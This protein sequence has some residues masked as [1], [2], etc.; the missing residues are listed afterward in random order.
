MVGKRMNVVERDTSF[1]EMVS[2]YKK[3]MGTKPKSLVAKNNKNDIL[4]VLDSDLASTVFWRDYEEGVRYVIEAEVDVKERKRGKRLKKL[5]IDV[6]AMA[7]KKGIEYKGRN[8]FYCTSC[9]KDLTLHCRSVIEEHLGSNKHTK[10]LTVALI[11]FLGLFTF[12]SEKRSGKV[13]KTV[14]TRRSLR[15]LHLE[16]IGFLTER[17]IKGCLAFETFRGLLERNSVSFQQV[18]GFFCLCPFCDIG[19]KPDLKYGHRKIVMT[20][21]DAYQEDVFNTNTLTVTI[22][23]ALSLRSTKEKST[24]L[25]WFTYDRWTLF[26]LTATERNGDES[27]RTY[28]DVFVYEDHKDKVKLKHNSELTIQVLDKILSNDFF[29]DKKGKT[30]RIWSDNGGSI[31]GFKTIYYLLS[32]IRPHFKSLTLNYFAPYHGK[33]DCD[34]H[35][36]CIRRKLYDYQGDVTTTNQLLDAV[37]GLSNTNLNELKKEELYQNEID[38]D[39]SLKLRMKNCFRITMK[40]HKTGDYTIMQEFQIPDTNGRVVHKVEK[41]CISKEKMEELKKRLEPASTFMNQI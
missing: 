29:K 23:Y 22:D 35:F 27:A 6:I 7:E 20:A 17:T 33:S 36:G 3:M 21:K 14:R 41:T 40:E 28:F 8:S 24:T 15:S 13:G 19:E 26:N 38:L 18:A 10:R 39:K 12:V 30:L 25:A 5:P 11:S 9:A 34:R 2:D 31:K 16:F 37:G 1:S 32:L 4:F